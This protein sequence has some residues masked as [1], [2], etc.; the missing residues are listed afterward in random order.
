MNKETES[1]KHLCTA[2]NKEL[3]PSQIIEIQYRRH[4]GVKR[5]LYFASFLICIKG[6]C[7]APIHQEK[8]ETKHQKMDVMYC[9]S[10]HDLTHTDCEPALFSIS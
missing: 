8:L 1:I 9:G 2:V 3:R 4:S 10:R 6:C 7:S 5:T